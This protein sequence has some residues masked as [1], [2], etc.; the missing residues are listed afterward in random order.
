M[1]P[2]NRLLFISLLALIIAIFYSTPLLRTRASKVTTQGSTDVR[3]FLG[4]QVSV[5]AA[6]RSAPWINLRDGHDLPADYQGASKVLQGLKGN[7]SRPLAL[8][9][10]DFDE[11]GVPDLV[12]AY[13]A[14]GGGVI[15]IQR[16]DADA[17]YPNSSEALSHRAQSTPNGILLP[18][19]DD[20]ASP[21]LLSSRAF[22]LSAAPH[23]LGTGDLDGDGHADLIA[24]T[25]GGDG[26]SFL[27]GDGHGGFAPARSIPLPGKVTALAT[28]DV[29]RMDGLAEIIVAISGTGGPRL[30]IFE[31]GAGAIKSVP[32]IIS[33]PAEAKSI[34]LGQLDGDYPVDIAVA[35]GHNLLIVHGR[36]R[37]LPFVEAKGSDAQP[38]ITRLSFS[39]SILSMAIGD[40]VGDAAQ[41]MVLLSDDGAARL[42]VK[43]A[44]QNGE[45]GWRES[46]ATVVPLSTKK[47]AGI[48]SAHVLVP[49]RISSSYKDDLLVMDASSHQLH[50]LINEATTSQPVP[51]Q[52]FSRLRVAASL[53]VEGE[54]VDVL[55]M[56]LNFDALSDL[57]LLRNNQSAPAIVI[58]SAATVFTVS[59]TN[60]SGA[61][62][63]RD[64]ISSANANP[65]ADT[66]NFNIPG[67]GTKTIKPLSS[68]PLISGTLTIDGTTQSPGSSVPPIE[69][70]GSLALP[71]TKGLSV[72]AANCVIR[73]LVI[74]SFDGNGVEMT[75]SSNTHVEG[76]FLGTN[77]SGTG[78]KANSE[79][80]VALISGN[81]N[82]VG[83]TTASARNVVSGNSS[84]GVV[85]LGS[86]T[87]N[88]VQSNYIGTDKTGAVSIGNGGD[89]ISLVSGNA[90]VTNSMIGSPTA[91]NVISGNAGFGVQFFGI[92]TGNLIQANLIG[93][94]AT[95]LIDVGNNSGGVAI[96][97]AAGNTVGGTVA[98]EGN[99]ISGNGVNGVRINT[100]TA[101][102]NRVQGNLIGTASNGISPL[103]NDS[104]GISVLNSA[105]STSIG[106][107]SGSGGNTIAFNGRNGVLI[108]TGT[109]NSILSNSIFSNS[110]LGIDLAPAGVTPNDAGD[111]D[112]GAN[113]LQNFPVLISAASTGG[114]IGIQGTLN[115]TPGTTFTLQFFASN[116]CDGS[117]NG[118][119]Q[120]FLGSAAATTNGSGNVAFN[121]TLVASASSGQYI[122][123]TATNPQG[124][125][126]ELSACVPFGSADLA[127][128]HTSAP[129]NVTAGNKVTY[130]INVTNNGPDAAVPAT[131]TDNL[132]PATSF[133]AC[134]S[135]G[136]GVCGGSGNNRIVSFNSIAPGASAVITIDAVV[137]CSVTDGFV[138][139]NTAAASSII[140][141]PVSGNN[142]ATAMN[143]VV[144]PPPSISPTSASFASDGGDESVSVTITVGCGWT[145]T[146]NAPWITVPNG[147]GGTGSGTLNYSVA[148]NPTGSPR[149]G[150]ITVAGLTFTVNQ[151]NQPC[152]YSI[153]PT[154]ASATAQGASGTV[155]VTALSGCKWKATSNNDWIVVTAGTAGSGSGA[156]SYTVAVNTNSN[157]RTGSISIGGQTFT[158]TQ[159]GVPC[160]YLLSRSSKFFGESGADDA[161]TVMAPGGCN[162]TA[163]PSA[164]WIIITS[165]TSGSGTDTI[166]YVVRDNFSTSPRQG[167]ITVGGQTFTIVQDGPTS[168]ECVFTL[169]PVSVSFTGAGGNGSVVVNCEDRCAWGAATNVGWITITSIGAGIG[170]KTVTYNVQ[171]NPGTSPRKGVITIAGK[172]HTIKQRGR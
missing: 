103:P 169:F 32:E 128:T 61:G 113:T 155:A 26:L 101:I 148:V 161:F 118:E 30:L 58:T 151:S 13:E 39:F 74:N 14:T 79:A 25:L 6:G 23:L 15:T 45:Q 70:D 28:G 154:S 9:A 100:V 96:S 122:T 108:E 163:V 86:A 126:S 112:S 48:S 115:S 52:I 54:P 49:L 162:W 47:S 41:E 80:G 33:L 110:A 107:A 24:A 63:L 10:A 99:V 18:A 131:V 8:A 109:A 19:I 120:V 4:R 69:L 134:F 104:D 98:G 20:L 38:V 3:G 1:K 89:G 76:N 106:A 172:T 53:D 85:I 157:P 44:P 168:G 95:G 68:L 170:T 102:N 83:G 46:S 92:G 60:D 11:D 111:A 149:T 132:P 135:T 43:A 150:T 105:S 65:G 36:D 2:S 50:I 17:I 56:R 160:N 66:I 22:E 167:T 93:T 156:V 142:S 21:F 57:V 127:I 37:K 67:T 64:A 164:S 51:A 130:T 97:D 147:S 159:A 116:S 77:A 12:S 16:G 81:D 153:M 27:S 166:T 143:I 139:N 71:G 94:D 171:A 42:M 87:G 146:S 152:S 73:G 129:A 40:F 31:S 165:E 62:S 123:A 29:N 91:G 90:S 82:V 34:A 119:G 140:H 133:V 88:K 75:S 35:A 136:G 84:H 117:G 59:N 5:H 114:G 125:T 72:S 124:N 55:P 138:I 141:D 7:Q 144:N 78:G 121:V 145:A 137:N 158:I